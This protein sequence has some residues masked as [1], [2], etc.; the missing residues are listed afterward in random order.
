[1][2]GALSEL[3]MDKGYHGT[4]VLPA[5][6]ELG[7]RSDIAE[8]QRGLVQMGGQGSREG[9]CPGLDVPAWREA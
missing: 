3:V 8:P 1:M 5:V 6:E 2:E 9:R 7:V 4:E